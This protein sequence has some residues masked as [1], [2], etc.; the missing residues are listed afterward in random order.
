M[1]NRSQW[2]RSRAR[3]HTQPAHPRAGHSR[4]HVTLTR[5]SSSHFRRASVGSRGASSG[6]FRAT[7]EEAWLCPPQSSKA[8]S[9]V[10]VFSTG[11]NVLPGPVL[12]LIST[13]PICAPSCRPTTAVVTFDLLDGAEAERRPPPRGL[14][15]DLGPR[16]RADA[17]GLS[18]RLGGLALG[19]IPTVAYVGRAG[20]AGGAASDLR[21]PRLQ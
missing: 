5:T 13:R 19:A 21:R 15:V 4:G 20:A 2:R 10:R 14:A 16:V 6:C 1:N 3:R 17:L 18:I 7:I 8:D 11:P 9:S 12:I